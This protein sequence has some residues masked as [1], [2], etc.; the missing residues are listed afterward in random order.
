MASVL[1]SMFLHFLLSDRARLVLS[2]VF[3]AISCLSIVFRSPKGRHFGESIPND[4]VLVGETKADGKVYRGLRW[5]LGS[6]VALRIHKPM[7]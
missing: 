1:F 3:V 6:S 7:K 5:R 4:A 2:L